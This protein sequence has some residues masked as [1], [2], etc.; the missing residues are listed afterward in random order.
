MIPNRTLFWCKVELGRYQLLNYPNLLVHLGH[1]GHPL[2]WSGRGLTDHLPKRCPFSQSRSPELHPKF[3]PCLKATFV[4][5]CSNHFS[6]FS[7]RKALHTRMW[8]ST[9]SP[10]CMTA[11]AL[12]VPVISS[13]VRL[14]FWSSSLWHGVWLSMYS[15]GSERLWSHALV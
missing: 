1:H 11:A 8:S 10:N 7:D 5:S 14:A 2:A 13:C 15:F 3:A 4:T 9:W 6:G 12:Q